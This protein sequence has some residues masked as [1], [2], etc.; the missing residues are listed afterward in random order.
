MLK[1]WY[2][3]IDNILFSRVFLTEVKLSG[4][5]LVTKYAVFIWKHTNKTPSQAGRGLAKWSQFVQSCL[6][7]I[8]AFS[9]RPFFLSSSVSRPNGLKKKINNISDIFKKNF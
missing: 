7:P 2:V 8:Q 1:V 3:C 9:A 6:S 5:P 4:I